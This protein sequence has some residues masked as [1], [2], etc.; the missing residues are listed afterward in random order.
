MKITRA[1]ALRGIGW[2]LCAGLI[3]GL[4]GSCGQEGEGDFGGDYNLE[5]FTYPLSSYRVITQGPAD[6]YYTPHQNWDIDCTIGDPILAPVAGQV[7]ETTYSDS[8]YGNS[9]GIAVAGWGTMHLNHLDTIAVEEGCAVQAGD[10]VATCG[11]TG[12]VWALNGGDG[13]HLDVYAVDTQGVNIDLPSPKYWLL[14]PNFGPATCDGGPPVDCGCEGTLDAA[15]VDGDALYVK[16]SLQCDAGIDKWSVVVHETTV[17]SEFP[18]SDAPVEFA[19][20][21]DLSGHDLAPGEA[22]VGLWARPNDGDACLLDKADVLL[23]P[24]G[25]DDCV[26]VGATLCWQ[27]D[28]YAQDSCGQLG[29]L[30]EAC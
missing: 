21:I 28:V 17:H 19:A 11:N 29:A 7:V 22:A 12:K 27:G 23:E 26:D 4:V 10:I 25:G 16:G 20:T 24:G 13:S 18:D 9:V 5:T 3:G 2:T 6:H 1:I 15:T 30:A 8:G 14:D